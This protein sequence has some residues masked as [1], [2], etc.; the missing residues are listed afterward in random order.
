MYDLSNINIRS[1]FI[2]IAVYEVQNF[3]TVA[4]REGI[5][6]SQ[7]SRVIH[8]L[9]DAVG[10][11]LFYRNTRA[12]IPTENGHIFIRYVRAVTSS[13]DAARRELNERTLE[14]SGLIRINAPVFLDKSMSRPNWRG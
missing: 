10:Q 4:R 2:F 7:V 6:A 12:I 8:Q 5:S 1:L 14:P 11:Q 13:L 9:E 3:S